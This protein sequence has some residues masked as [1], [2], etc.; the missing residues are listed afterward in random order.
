M[1]FSEVTCAANVINLLESSLHWNIWETTLA[2]Q[3]DFSEE[4]FVTLP[5]EDRT[6][7]LATMENF[8]SFPE[9]SSN[10]W[11]EFTKKKRML[12]QTPK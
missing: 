12:M 2:T 6:S 4:C 9:T 1:F 5:F 3:S 11:T 8:H 7:S 10:R